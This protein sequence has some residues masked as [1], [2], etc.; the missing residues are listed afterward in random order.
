[1]I[2]NITGEHF[3]LL[4]AVEPTG[5]KKWG[6]SLWHCTCQCGGTHIA[7][8]NS[9]KR[10]LVRSCGC[11]RSISSKLKAN[12]HGLR[13]TPAYKSWDSM[14]QRC[15]NANNE[16]YK[17]YG[18]LGI[19]VCDRWS[20][21]LNFLEDMGDRPKGMSLDR[22]DSFGNYDPENCRWATAYEQSHNKRKPI[23]TYEQAED[24]RIRYA[25]GEGPKSICASTG[26]STGSVNGIVY[27]NQISKPS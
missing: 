27:L 20:S 5:E 8:V 7:A 12:F 25:A 14:I 11:L 18:A 9:L 17:K 16:S 15:R 6:V 3:G 4:T 23:T 22:I 13:G 10:G 21:F 26:L 19:S 2:R 1:M 24:V